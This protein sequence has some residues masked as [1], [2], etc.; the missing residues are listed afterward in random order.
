[1]N[2]VYSAIN[3]LNFPNIF[4]DLLPQGM[5]RS[6]ISTAS[7]PCFVQVRS[8][9]QI[10]PYFGY[11]QDIHSDYPQY[12]GLFNSRMLF[13]LTVAVSLALLLREQ[14]YRGYCNGS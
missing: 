1:M 8:Q 13:P 6:D 11:V 5:Y 9:S 4:S 3:V 10:Q 14:P 12:Y 2:E 7:G